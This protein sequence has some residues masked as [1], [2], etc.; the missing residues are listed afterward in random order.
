MSQKVWI[1][2]LSFNLSRVISRRLAAPLTFSLLLSAG[3]PLTV[4]EGMRESSVSGASHLMSA[5]AQDQNRVAAQKKFEEGEALRAQGTAE[6]LRLAV[7]KYEE[8]LPLWR[9]IGDPR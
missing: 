6:S 9:R 7:K 5:P 3:N 1:R 2:K 8:A 4:I